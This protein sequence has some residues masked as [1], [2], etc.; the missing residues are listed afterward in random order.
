MLS[1]QSMSKRGIPRVVF[2]MEPNLHKK[3][4]R[5]AKKNQRK[6]VSAHAKAVYVDHIE[7]K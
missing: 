7:S 3:A 6:S 2:E 5:L 4:A 1:I